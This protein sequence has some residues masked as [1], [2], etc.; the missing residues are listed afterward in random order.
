MTR[1]IPPRFRLAVALGVVWLTFGSA[2]IG[3]K[4]GV[5][6]VPPFFFA[7]SRF[8]IAG[9]LLLTFCAWRAGWRLRLT[10]RELGE[11][12]LVGIAMILLG[13]GTATWSNTIL[14]PGIVAVLLSTMPLWAALLGRVFLGIR[15]SAVAGAG[16]VAG[17]GGVCLLAAPTGSG[18]QL[19]PVVALTGA[20]LAWAAGTLIAARSKVAGRPLLLSAL[21]MLIGGALQ[22]VAGVALG[23]PAH[24]D[25]TAITPT[26]L[27]TFVYLLL[28]VSLLGFTLL[29]WIVTATT[30]TVV[31]SQAFVVPVVALALGWLLLGEPVGARTLVASGISLLGVVLLVVGQARARS[32]QQAP[33]KEAELE[34]AA[35]A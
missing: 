20:S 7:G 18:I 13:Q 11:A 17:F 23:E 3:A 16:L 19:L 32:R 33:A 24:L 9:A 34:H 25:L 28:G 31:T 26:V 35:A 5:A 4:V 15:V 8:L 2:F 10:W 12:A 21:Q 1:I 22:M 14:T 27:V 29:S 30:P 6:V